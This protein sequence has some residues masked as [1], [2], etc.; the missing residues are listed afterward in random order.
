MTEIT[1]ALVHGLICRQFPQWSNLS[2]KPVKKSGNDNR[3]FHLG[4]EMT[5]RLPS[6][7]C[8]AA[9]VEKEMKWLPIL[10]PSLSLPISSPIAKGSPDM[11]FPY[12]WS[13][14]HY[15]K[16]ETV[17]HENVLDLTQLAV[18][19][20]AFLKE[21]QRI[22]TAG[23]PAAGQHNFYRGG[24]LSVYDNE[25][26]SALN[27]WNGQLP[28]EMLQCIWQRAI[29]SKWTG[30]PVWIHG[31]IAP[32]NLLIHNGRLCGVI[33]FGIMG[34][35]DPSCDYAMAWTFF[36]QESRRSFIKTLDKDTADRARGWALWKAL[37][38]YDSK[39][40]ENALN[41]KST[42]LSI[43]QEET[44]TSIPSGLEN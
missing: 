35:G 9:Q 2:I 38:T 33:D 27:K 30:N 13:V 5:V 14:N 25:T 1:T 10:K 32:G 3:T 42:I 26:Q 36:D 4:E 44:G 7:G 6:S 15:I 8:Y 29:S 28:A 11:D 12:P 23:A 39:D 20:S 43:I 16:G 17:S 40:T 18:D 41:A 19:L 24:D 31:D 37:I 22:D 21:L 34:I